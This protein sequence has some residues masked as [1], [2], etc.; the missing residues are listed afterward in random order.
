MISALADYD[1]NAFIEAETNEKKGILDAL[2]NMKN[3]KRKE[4]RVLVD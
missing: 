3:Y 1:L 4:K 2:D